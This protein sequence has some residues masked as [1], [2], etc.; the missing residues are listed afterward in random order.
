M[1]NKQTDL[2]AMNHGKKQPQSCFSFDSVIESTTKLFG[3]QGKQVFSFCILAK[4]LFNSKFIVNIRR[5]EESFC[6]VFW[7]C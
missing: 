5:T 4:P 6:C 7:F 1:E 2:D 3:S